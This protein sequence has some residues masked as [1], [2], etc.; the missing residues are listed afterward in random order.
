MTED[1]FH[2]CLDSYGA[3]LARWPDDVRAAAEQ[4]IASDAS[5][6]DAFNAAR[7]IDDLIVRH[8]AAQG[9]GNAAGARVLAKL[10]RPLPRQKS[11][12]LSRLPGL[13]LDL[14]FAPAW[15]RVAALACCAALGFAI[16]LAGVDRRIDGSNVAAAS[17]ADLTT[18]MFEPEPLTGAR[19]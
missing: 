2:R 17:P 4:S 15:P 6:R 13:L 18:A 14:Q 5:A 7:R 10:A 16:G 19:P 8:L 3:D 12:L 11:R 1:Q 9:D